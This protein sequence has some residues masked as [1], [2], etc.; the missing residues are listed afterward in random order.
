M[1]D[2]VVIRFATAG[3]PDVNRAFETLE[4]RMR[5]FEQNA[6]RQVEDSSKARVRATRTEVDERERAYQKMVREMAR[7]EEKARDAAAKAEIRTAEK[8]AKEIERL[9]EQK[10]RARIRASEMATRAA[11]RE[12]EKESR[13]IAAVHR[14]MGGTVAGSFGSSLGSIGAF[15]GATLGLGGGFMLA[16]ALRS[17]M[18]AG[19]AAALLANSATIGGVAPEGA[20]VANILAQATAAS[21]TYG[22]DKTD[23]IGSVQNYVA[24]SSDFKGGMANMGFFAKA[25]VGTGTRLEDITSMAGILRAQNKD[26]GAGD[27]Q[28]MILDTIE[29]GKLG[30]VEISD[31]AKLAGGLGSTR[32][33]Y[34]GNTADNQRKLMALAQITMTEGTSAEEAAIGVKDLGTEAL[35]KSRKKN[36]P[37]WLKDV[38]KGGQ[39]SSLEG[40]LEAGLKGTG[41]DLGQLIDIFDS[42]GARAFER[43]A[44]IYK[45]A[46]GGDKGIAAVRAEMAP[47]LGAKGSQENLD[48]MYATVMET[49]AKRIEKAFNEVE[50]T[51]GER[52]E[53]RLESFARD[54]LPALSEHF[55]DL[56]DKGGKLV[57]W[58]ANNPLLGVGALIA[59]KVGADISQAAIGESIKKTMETSIGQKLGSGFAIASAAFT[60]TE[61]GMITIDRLMA[62]Q[63][64]QQKADIASDITSTNTAGELFGKVRSGKVTAADIK[65][66]QELRGEQAAVADKLA[67]LA[68]PE[69]FADP[70]SGA[71]MGEGAA[72]PE[73]VRAAKLAAESLDMLDKA[74]QAATV[75]LQQMQSTASSVKPPVAPISE[76]EHT[77]G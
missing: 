1:I 26:L 77:P 12:A 6:S 8:A 29:Q 47:I 38:T 2:P 13:E 72:D 27:M 31:L 33:L 18:N 58:M 68:Q 64:R 21:K 45:G 20:N 11:A 76:R 10:L 36:A 61:V 65:K 59:T 30:A 7:E 57:E 28:Q 16:G 70:M 62:E 14:R 17:Q 51:I 46:G 35:K 39:I 24:K 69:Q 71:I 42:K 22:V 37:K 23:L 40:L 44:P 50:Q 53:P 74:I 3:M 48:Q 25:S 34:K 75:S 54:T 19:K 15:T 56:V 9:E 55:V 5:R 66:A 41:G 63:V 32:G 67:G 4:Q 49:P 60:I 73:A 52:L 43:L